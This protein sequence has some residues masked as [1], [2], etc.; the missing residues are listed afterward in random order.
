MM[1][2]AHTGCVDAVRNNPSHHFISFVGLIYLLRYCD[3]EQNLRNVPI[4]NIRKKLAS[5]PHSTIESQR[6]R[7]FNRCCVHRSVHSIFILE[8]CSGGEC[9]QLA[10][11]LLSVYCQ[12]QRCSFFHSDSATN[13][14]LQRDTVQTICRRFGIGNLDVNQC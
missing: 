14:S 13:D 11:I 5:K 4:E 3:V 7:A 9:M 12:L 8:R 10:L 1:E 2:V 6:A